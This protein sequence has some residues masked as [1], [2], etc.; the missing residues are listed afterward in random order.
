LP[1]K[2]ARATLWRLSPRFNWV[3]VLRRMASSSIYIEPAQ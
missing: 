3:R 2:T 1:W